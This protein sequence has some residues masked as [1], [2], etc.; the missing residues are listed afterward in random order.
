[1]QTQLDPGREGPQT[2]DRRN[3]ALPYVVIAI[4]WWILA[5]VALS[6]RVAAAFWRPVV[7]LFWWQALLFEKGLGPGHAVVARLAVLVVY[8]AGGLA[9]WRILA[10]LRAAER[11][12]WLLALAASVIVQLS[13]TG[14]GMWLAPE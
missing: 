3:G 1:V 14:L 10:R 4:L 11:H 13:L 2:G 6:I 12:P 9:G 7:E 5:M 8:L